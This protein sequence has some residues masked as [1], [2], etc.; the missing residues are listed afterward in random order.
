MVYFFA[1]WLLVGCGFH[2]SADSKVAISSLVHVKI[3]QRVTLKILISS[4]LIPYRV[5]IFRM[6][7]NIK[8]LFKVFQVIK[9]YIQPNLRRTAEGCSLS[10]FFLLQN[11]IQYIWK[12]GLRVFISNKLPGGVTLLVC[13]PCLKQQGSRILNCQTDFS[14]CD[15]FIQKELYSWFYKCKIFCQVNP[16][17]F[18]I[19][20]TS[21]QSVIQVQCEKIS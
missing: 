3:I 1:W 14:C 19:V 7:P 15:V 13:V 5:T 8:Y 11:V 12:Q 17:N 9:L 2:L 20:T 6:S 10:I 4:L 16:I 18:F 21:L